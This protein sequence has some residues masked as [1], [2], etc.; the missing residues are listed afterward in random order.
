MD[1][2]F[3]P[4][5]ADGESEDVMYG[6]CQAVFKK[7]PV[8]VVQLK[9]EDLLRAGGYCYAAALA[10]L[11]VQELVDLGVLRGHAGMIMV[12][13]WLWVLRW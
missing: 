3:S 13:R 4:A 5:G 9:Y 1:P 11:T 6:K 8:G 7:L 2:V 10:T 12:V